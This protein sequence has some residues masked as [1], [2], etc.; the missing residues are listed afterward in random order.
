M[1]DQDCQYKYPTYPA[2]IT[3]SMFCASADSADSC[4]GDSGGPFTV[5]HNNIS[6]LEGVVSW[7]KSCAKSKWP[8]V[9]ARV[10]TV[11]DWIKNNIK[12]SNKCERN[13]ESPV[14]LSTMI[15][16]VRPQ[17]GNTITTESSTTSTTISSTLSTSTTISTNTYTPTPNKRSVFTKV[18]HL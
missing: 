7:G 3:P 18:N 17:T 13:E 2:I 12:E 14:T 5:L 6:I 8:G 16:N 10:R 1:K 9:Y 11:L 15:S 4:Y